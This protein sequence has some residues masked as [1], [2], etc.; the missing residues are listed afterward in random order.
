MT[1][2][3]LTLLEKCINLEA[4]NQ[5]LRIRIYKLNSILQELKELINGYE[6]FSSKI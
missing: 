1:Q 3:D 2:M 5:M 6:N 4:E